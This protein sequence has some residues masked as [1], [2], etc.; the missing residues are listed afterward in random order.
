MGEGRQGGVLGDQQGEAGPPDLAREPAQELGAGSGPGAGG[1]AGGLL[2]QI[3]Q[4]LEPVLDLASAER[5]E[6]V[7]LPG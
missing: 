2:V 6:P 1:A 7:P 3:A 5:A 4:V